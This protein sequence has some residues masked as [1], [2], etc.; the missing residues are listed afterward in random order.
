MNRSRQAL[1][2]AVALWVVVIAAAYGFS[3]TEPPTAGEEQTPVALLCWLPSEI[4]RFEIS[5]G[6]EKRWFERRAWGWKT[7]DGKPVDP[8]ALDVQLSRLRQTKFTADPKLKA[9]HVGLGPESERWL[10]QRGDA[11]CELSLGL[12]NQVSGR[13]YFWRGVEKVLGSIDDKAIARIAWDLTAKR[14]AYLDL[15]AVEEIDLRSEI[16]PSKRFKRSKG[17]WSVQSEEAKLR[18]DELAMTELLETFSKGLEGTW[19]AKPPDLTEADM[20]ASLK[21]EN[22]AIS[23]SF[24]NHESGYL[25]RNEQGQV[26][27]LNQDPFRRLRQ[28]IDVYRDLQVIHYERG[29]VSALVMQSEAGRFRYQRRPQAQGPDLW[30]DGERRIKDS[31][32]LAAM[33]WDLHTLRAKR[34]LGPPLPEP[35]VCLNPC[36]QVQAIDIKG[37]TSVDLQIW[38]QGEDYELIQKAGPRLLV[39]AKDL[40]HWPFPKVD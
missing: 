8:L 12:V 39:M 27:R 9:E 24:F 34:Y 19:L 4:D 26:F 30:F 14:A 7:S 31:Y 38:P 18:C 28:N 33:Q 16:G 17:L 13:R 11:S 3:K 22:L 20:T 6:E 40:I 21:G 10:F 15:G 36:R 1:A 37:E 32:R 5:N 23:L 2:W 29:E 35:R 25:L